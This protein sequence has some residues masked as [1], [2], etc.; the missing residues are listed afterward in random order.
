MTE[1]CIDNM[2]DKTILILIACIALPIAIIGA[3]WE[4]KTHRKSSYKP[5]VREMNTVFTGNMDS[6]VTGNIN[7][8][9]TASMTVN[10][11]KIAM[12]GKRLFVNGREWGPRG[13][14]GEPAGPPPEPAILVLDRDGTIQGNIPGDLIIKVA[15]SSLGRPVVHITVNGVIGGSVQTESGD[16]LC[17]EI[18]HSVTATGN[19]NCASVDGSVKSG[20]DVSCNN[21]GGSV[22]AAGNVRCQNV[23]G[24]VKSEQNVTC[25]IVGGSVKASTVTRT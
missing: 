23:G 22:T 21:V 7:A 9:G 19:V 15:S 18:G 20:G 8:G 16:T 14:N 11:L 10:G 17:K 13:E 25:G 1:R 5:K 6:I 2:D 3:I 4:Y 24:S 12:R